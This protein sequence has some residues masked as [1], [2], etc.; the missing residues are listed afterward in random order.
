MTLPVAVVVA[1]Y[2]YQLQLSAESVCRVYTRVDDRLQESLEG[3]PNLLFIIHY[4]RMHSFKNDRENGSGQNRTSR[5]ACYSQVASLE[6][7]TIGKADVT[8]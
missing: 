8:F 4:L 1:R 6:A 7:S 3:P 5:T 2:E